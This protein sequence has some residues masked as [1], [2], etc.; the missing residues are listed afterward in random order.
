MCGLLVV[1]VLVV[2]DAAAATV[3][4]ID[5]DDIPRVRKSEMKK[6]REGVRGR[7]IVKSLLMRAKMR[8]HF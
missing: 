8:L 5:V 6:R 2:V 3:V 7:T 1:V 4:D